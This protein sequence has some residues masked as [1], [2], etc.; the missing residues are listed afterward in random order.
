[1]DNGFNSRYTT[2]EPPAY[3]L[4]LIKSFSPTNPPLFIDWKFCVE[5]DLIT[6][7][8]IVDT[9]RFAAEYMDECMLYIIEIVDVY[10]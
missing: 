9:P 2:S 6:I 7:K 3:Y 8:T 4:Y 1:M 5:K 10:V